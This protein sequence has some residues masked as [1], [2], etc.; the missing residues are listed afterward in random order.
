MIW[1][2]YVQYNYI[3]DGLSDSTGKG[4]VY[5]AELVGTAESLIASLMKEF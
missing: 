2:G 4:H 5:Q 1:P 3:A